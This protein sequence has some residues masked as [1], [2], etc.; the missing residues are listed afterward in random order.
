MAISNVKQN[1]VELTELDL[2]LSNVAHI[3]HASINVTNLERS[4]WFFTE[5]LGLH[6]TAEEDGQGLSTSMA[7]LGSSH[8]SS[9][10][11]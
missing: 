8:I 11:S 1:E 9:Q 5:V 10:S 3:G 6:V 4:T 2:K 7:G